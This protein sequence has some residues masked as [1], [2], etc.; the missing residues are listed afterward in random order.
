MSMSRANRCATYTHAPDLNHLL[1]VLMLVSVAYF[2][3]NHVCRCILPA[4]NRAASKP[5]YDPALAAARSRAG[6]M[7]PGA[8]AATA[9]HGSA[10]RAGKKGPQAGYEPGYDMEIRSSTYYR[11]DSK[12]TAAGMGPAGPA[13]GG[14]SRG[15][16]PAAA[17][18]GSGAVGGYSSRQGIDANNGYAAAGALNGAGGSSPLKGSGSFGQRSGVQ[19][20]LSGRSSS[21]GGG[22]GGFGDAG[23]N[24]EAPLDD[25]LSHVNSLIKVRVY[26]WRKEYCGHLLIRR[27]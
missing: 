15:R 1:D 26:C 7:Y 5:S 4:K 14:Q 9:A 11:P 23:L 25:L 8:K 16:S 21:G 17:A 27:T 19:R 13:S 18:A 10:G 2:C 12:G 22:F 3:C 24:P 6:L 20:Q